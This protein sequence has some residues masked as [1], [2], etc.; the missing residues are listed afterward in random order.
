MNKEMT[1]SNRLDAAPTAATEPRWGLFSATAL[2]PIGIVLSASALVGLCAHIIIPLP[3]TPVPMS[4][5]P[6][7]V[8][9]LG[10]VLSPG[11][12]AAALL[13]YLGE[14]VVGLPVF[15]PQGPGGLVHLLGP[16]GGYLMAFPLGAFVIASIYRR[17]SKGFSAAAASALSGSVIMIGGGAL[18]LMLITHSS[19]NAVLAIAVVPFLAA[20]AVKILAAAALAKGWQRLRH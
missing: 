16:T 7:A 1:A 17:T 19:L 15:A 18:W 3:F 9:L 13:A 12:A 8:L 2:R 6:F 5:A 20:D 10:L 11:M 4:M 14:G